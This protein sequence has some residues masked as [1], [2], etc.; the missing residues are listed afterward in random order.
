MNS[1]TPKSFGDREANRF[2]SIAIRRKYVTLEK[3]ET[4]LA[5]Q[6]VDDVVGMPRRRLDEILLDHGWITEEQ[7]KTVLQEMGLFTA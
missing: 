6:L 3:V 7:V 4:A 2:G 5:E 1:K